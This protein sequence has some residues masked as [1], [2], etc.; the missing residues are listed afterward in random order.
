MDLSQNY[1]YEKNNYYNYPRN[2]MRNK[3]SRKQSPH[4]KD[5]LINNNN[6]L[7]FSLNAIN[8]ILI[9]NLNSS[10][11]L[12]LLNITNENNNFFPKELN[13]TQY[14]NSL[15][16]S[17]DYK[18]RGNIYKQ[19]KNIFL[20][21]YPNLI[22]LLKNKSCNNKNKREIK[23]MK[24]DKEI[25]NIKNKTPTKKLDKHYYLNIMK[26]NKV[27]SD[28]YRHVKNN[29]ENIDNNID[30]DKDNVDNLDIKKPKINNNFDKYTIYR[31]CTT[32]N[33]ND[34]NKQ[35]YQSNNVMPNNTK[36]YK[37]KISPKKNYIINKTTVNSKE[38]N[39][40]DNQNNNNGTKN[41]ISF[42]NKYIYKVIKTTNNSPK[43]LIILN[44]NQENQLKNQTK[45]IP[46]KKHSL[47]IPNQLPKKIKHE[48][49]QSYNIHSYKPISNTERN[50]NTYF[51]SNT[52]NNKKIILHQN[53]NNNMN[54]NK[55]NQIKYS[56]LTNVA[57]L[58]KTNSN[59]K[60]IIIEK[61][62]KNKNLN[63]PYISPLNKLNNTEISSNPKN[64][65]KYVLC[66]KAIINKIKINNS[67]NIQTTKNVVYQKTQTNKSIIPNNEKNKNNNDV[68]IDDENSIFKVIDNT[69]IL[70]PDEFSNSKNSLMSSNKFN[71]LNGSNGT[72]T[73]QDTDYNSIKK[74]NNN[75]FTNNDNKYYN[76]S[77]YDINFSFNKV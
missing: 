30:T 33:S 7:Q 73:N 69:Q 6:I 44:K 12:G 62:Q 50:T 74:F 32:I 35:I 70:T 56:T 29:S 60:K 42:K 17:I 19:N 5:L 63:I 2:N 27:N 11:S 1:L 41:Q 8:N 46:N 4:K 55:T 40:K 77:G 61:S 71:Q 52:N 53:C 45:E 3:K 26:S 15:Y 20:N 49:A 10:V 22:P 13:N 51:N 31:T 76:N 18:I 59:N 57:N 65:N 43:K 23:I 14:I 68:F 25:I 66:N 36:T 24:F 21:N 38:K 54:I 37:K 39:I 72:N 58:K 64:K 28:K 67:N 16:D 48:H 34:K 47:L 75:F 9:N